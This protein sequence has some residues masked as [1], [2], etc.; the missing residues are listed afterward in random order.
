MAIV[1][2]VVVRDTNDPLHNPSTYKVAD[3]VK[4]NRDA[5]PIPT[6]YELA[7]TVNGLDIYEQEHSTDLI[8][9]KST[10]ILGCP[11]AQEQDV[12][13]SEAEQRTIS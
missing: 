1:N 13:R 8:E 6:K 5:A 12:Y 11:Q 7:G 2:G 4:M 10:K 3:R 9:H